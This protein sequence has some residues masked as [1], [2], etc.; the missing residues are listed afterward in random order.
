MYLID[1]FNNRDEW[2]QHR[3]RHCIH[4]RPPVKLH[5]SLGMYLDADVGKIEDSLKEIT[6]FWGLFS[7]MTPCMYP[8]TMGL[9]L[10]QKAGRT[11]QV[12]PKIA[13]PALNRCVNALCT[14]LWGDFKNWWSYTL[15]D[16]VICS[17]VYTDPPP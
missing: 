5:V 17:N 14:T 9:V 1:D 12:S 6:C 8:S 16:E 7:H 10:G 4:F 11:S 13:K 3:A 2:N 15:P